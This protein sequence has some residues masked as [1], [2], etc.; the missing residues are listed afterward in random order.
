MAEISLWDRILQNSTA[1]SLRKLCQSCIRRSELLSCCKT[2]A[3]LAKRHLL[4]ELITYA[5]SVW[6][7]SL[8]GSDKACITADNSA[9]LM[10]CSPFRRAVKMVCKVAGGRPVA[11]AALACCLRS[12]SVWHRFQKISFEEVLAREKTHANWIQA[13]VQNSDASLR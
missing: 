7:Q 10:V 6:M 13:A 4:T 8:P 5:L 9:R 12:K 3:E 11:R 1:S 2:S